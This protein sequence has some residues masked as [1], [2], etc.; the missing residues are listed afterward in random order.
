MRF[1]VGIT[2]FDWYRFLAASPDLDEVNFWQPSA[3]RAPVAL[4]AGAPFLFKLHSAQ[5]GFV[6]GGGFVARYSKVPVYLAWEAFGAKNGAA[7]RE[8]M[9][10]RIQHYRREPINPNHDEIGCMI[11][12]S[13]FFLPRDR[14]VAPPEDWAPNI[15]QGKTYHDNEPIGA[16]VWREV[17][18]AAVAIVPS[19]IAENRYGLPVL[20]APRLGQGEF[21][22]AVTD[23]YDRRCAMTAERTLPAL[24]AA[25]II[26]YGQNGE[27]RLDNGLLL[28]KD[29]HALFDAGYLGI[30]SDMRVEVSPRIREDYEN[31]RDYYALAG[32]EL[33]LPADPAARPNPVFLDWHASER[34]LR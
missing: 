1:W 2:D 28:R 22:I 24:D 21:R 16:R 26:P 8:E 14:W 3:G 6:V 12:S 27:H 17:Q 10:A 13:P 4:P 32:R 30:G 20:V 7:S 34:F 9:I 5:G 11:L 29:L 25:H 31:G 19:A 15:V 18:Q 33:R 23:A